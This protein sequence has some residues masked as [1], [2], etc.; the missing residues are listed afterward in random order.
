MKRA[1]VMLV[2]TVMV[3][4]I[5][6]CGI[7][8]KAQMEALARCTY[9]I[10]SIDKMLVGG[11]SIESFDSGNGVNIAS[12]PSIAF[13]ILR[14]DLPLEAKVNLK[15]SNTNQKLAAIN[16]FKYLIEIKGTPIFEGTVDENIKLST[17]E[18]AVV[19]LSF[20]LNLFGKDK[21]SNYAEQILAEI[22]KKEK[23]DNFMTLKIKP[24]FK[25]GESNIYYPTYI[26][27]DTNLL[28][29]IKI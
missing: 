1:I 8:K 2:A 11:K 23:S 6:G 16:Q 22:F 24:S 26:T 27:V 15:V 12:L 17:G 21:N 29:K 25:I 19:P 4:L 18:S 14:Q 10:E 7:N 9:S 3:S 20:K 5:S 13:A 28:K